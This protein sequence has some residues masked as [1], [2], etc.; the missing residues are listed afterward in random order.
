MCTSL[1]PRSLPGILLT[2]Q[3][4]RE[5]RVMERREV[6]QVVCCER[7]L[8]MGVLTC[9]CF[10]DSNPFTFTMFVPF[11]RSSSSAGVCMFATSSCDSTSLPSL[12]R[13]R[14]RS[15]SPF[16]DADLAHTRVAPVTAAELS[17]KWWSG[18]PARASRTLCPLLLP[19]LLSLC[20]SSFLI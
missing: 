11:S 9:P 15:L 17:G 2:V 20:S 12:S 3:E 7:L 6:L 18:L 16:P 5:D 8:H 4:E 14:A 19:L 10:P 1:S 13:P